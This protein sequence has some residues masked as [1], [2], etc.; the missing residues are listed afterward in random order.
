[1]TINS[2]VDIFFERSNKIFFP[3]DLL[4]LDLDFSKTE[5]FSLIHL[6]GR[7]KVTMSELVEYINTPMSTATGIIDRLEKKGFVLRGR[8]DK[9][10]RIVVVGLSEKGREFYNELRRTFT[11]YLEYVLSDLSAE[12][13][14]FLVRI[15]IKM[16]N[17]LEEEPPNSAEEA[18]AKTAKLKN[19]SIE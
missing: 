15:A 8:S 13:M 11:S 6:A 3:A 2:F 12:E 9:D 19:I 5:L 14:A 1:M 7:E 17:K 4:K 18:K 16:M 10:R